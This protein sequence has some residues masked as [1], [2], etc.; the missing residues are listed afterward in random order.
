MLLTESV[1]IFLDANVGR[2]CVS[3]VVLHFSTC[4]LLPAMVNRLS[5]YWN[6]AW[7]SINKALLRR[8][9]VKQVLHRTV[10]TPC[11]VKGLKIGCRP[12][13]PIRTFLLISFFFGW[14]NPTR[15][16]TR[17][18]PPISGGVLGWLCIFVWKN[19]LDVLSLLS[20]EPDC[21]WFG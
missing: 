16:G 12:K 14:T 15:G 2:G 17:S 20:I 3:F 21:R 9:G 1:G 6:K 7:T 5:S 10:R 18:N 19:V 13:Q 4:R 8:S 11:E